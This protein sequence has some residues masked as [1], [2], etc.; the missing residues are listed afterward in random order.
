VWLL[1]AQVR[2]RMNRLPGQVYKGRNGIRI[3]TVTNS[4][5]LDADWSYPVE[6]E[7]ARVYGFWKSK[8]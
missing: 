7:E 2:R 6:V 3:G 8:R 4:K 5:K 1:S